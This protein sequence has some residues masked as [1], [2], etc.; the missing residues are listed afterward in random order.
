MRL[1][2]AKTKWLTPARFLTMG[3]LIVISIGAFLLSLP[4][5]TVNGQGLNL[6][7]ALFTATSAT[8]VTGL[9][10]V[11]TATYLTRFGQSV[12][13]LLIQIGGFG[14]M[15]TSTLFALLLGR[16]ITFRERIIIREELNHFSLSGV[17]KLARYVIV[18]TLAI[19]LSGALL[20]FFKFKNNLPLSQAIFFSV[21]HAIS[22]FCNAGFALFSNSLENFIGDYYI[23][24]VIT[25]LFILGGLGFAVIADL[26]Q[27]RRFKALSLNSKLVLVTT[28]ILILIGTIGIFLLELSNPDT[29]GELTLKDELISA[30]FQGVTPRT[31]GFNTIPIG[32]LTQGSLF[33]IIILM[34]IGASPGST[35]G[36]LKTTTIG[37][38]IVATYS[39]IIGKQDVELFKRRLSQITVYKALAVTIVSLLVIIMATLTLSITERFDFIHVFF[40]TVSAYATVGLSTGITGDLSTIGRVLI[41]IIMFTGRV[42]PLTLAMALGE[43]EKNNK[44]RY[45]EEKIL[46]G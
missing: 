7:D 5:A 25:T 18:L 28:L 11:D 42:G 46:I 30:Y 32:K 37:V 21:F 35:G 4:M 24:F 26:Y 22:A 40:E 12:V 34:F 14:F 36:G 45:P 41:T 2:L 8:A 23:N 44:I 1:I 39:L 29:F 15:T 13:L 43:R 16:K 31:A 3:Y 17:I 19:E 20:L 6:V 27:K 33:L 38:L 10:V 9:I